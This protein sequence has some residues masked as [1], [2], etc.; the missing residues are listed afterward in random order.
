MPQPEVAAPDRAN[1]VNQELSP[2]GHPPDQLEV[3]L[4]S[5]LV[6]FKPSSPLLFFLEAC[7]ATPNVS[8][9]I[10]RGAAAFTH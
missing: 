3:L 9:M 5:N 10:P 4:G 2:L 7:G 8:A 1:T 6:G